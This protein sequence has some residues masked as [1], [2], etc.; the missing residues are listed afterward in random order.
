MEAAVLLLSETVSNAVRHGLPGRAITVNVT[1]SGPHLRVGVRNLG[2]FRP[3]ARRPD[4]GGWGLVL[5]QGLAS[6]WGI[7]VDQA[8]VETWF[9]L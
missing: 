8:S 4:E 6:R 1:R 3:P 2:R 7:E 5:V 9:E